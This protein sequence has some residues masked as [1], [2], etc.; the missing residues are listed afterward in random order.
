MDEPDQIA[1]Q[2]KQLPFE[3]KALEGILSQV[4]RQYY[5]RTLLLSPLVK[6]LLQELSSRKVDPA[7][8][9][10]LLPMKVGVSG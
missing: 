6:N 4:C 8:L 9:H 10:K 1:Q 2:T 7:T 5:N 3:C